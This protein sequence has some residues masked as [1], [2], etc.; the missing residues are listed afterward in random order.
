MATKQDRGTKRTCQ[1]GDCGAR[2]YDLNRSPILCPVCSTKYVIASS[3][4][5]VAAVQAEKAAPRKPKKEEFA[6]APVAEEA[7]A[8]EEEL[9]DV[10]TDETVADE[11]ETFL[12]EEEEEGDVSNIIGPVAEDEQP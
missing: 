7:A 5:A 11:D 6:P 8:A 9:A 10:E 1:N 4:M 12:E 3:P 2:F